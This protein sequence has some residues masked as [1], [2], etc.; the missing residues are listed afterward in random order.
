MQG[1]TRRRA[2]P[3]LSSSSSVGGGGENYGGT[4]CEESRARCAVCGGGHA[5]VDTAAA[6]RSSK[7]DD[8][9]MRPCVTG[10]M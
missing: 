9:R 8:E 6:G 2:H 10:Q 5:D 4:S 3:S 1:V 7:N